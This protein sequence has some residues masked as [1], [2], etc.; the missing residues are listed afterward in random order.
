MSFLSK[1]TGRYL[2][3]RF[4]HQIKIEIDEVEVEVRVVNT[5]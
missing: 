3:E 1:E 4:P 5:E 2:S